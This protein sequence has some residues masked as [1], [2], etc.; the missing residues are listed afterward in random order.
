MISRIDLRGSL[1]GDLRSV[2][3]RAE[4]DV[5][6]AL[7]KVRPICED[8]RHRGSDAVREYTRAFD[9]V[10]LESTRVPVAAVH[11]ALA[12][13]DPAV[14][15]ALEESIR[16]AR[17]VHR[18]QRRTDV[19]T[20][21]APGGTV[22]E[23]WIP[24]GRVGL[25]VPGGRAVYPSSVVM[26]VVPAQEAGVGSLAVTS[27]AQKDFGGLP[28]PTILAACALLGVDEVYAAGG[29]QAIAMFAYGTG[30]CPR[31][32][33]VTGPGN[34]YVAAAKRLLKG[35]IGIDAEAGPTEIAIL[36]DDTASPVDVAA[37][38]ISQA[39]HD[40]LAAAVLVTDSVRLA[41]EVETE[42]KAQVARTRHTE[43]I[44]EALAG[45]QSGIVL[46]DT[47]EDGL[48]V[49]DAYAA[50]HLEIQTA[51]AAAVAARVRNAGAVF[52]GPHAPVSLG[53]YL[54]GSNHVLPTGGCACH[55]SG[56]SVQSFLRGVHVVE[57]DRDAL[58]E[59]TARV[60][61]LAEAEDLPAHGAAL[62]AR[63][64]WEIPS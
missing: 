10:E 50:E 59:A 51:D 14:R 1:P 44:T 6:A 31:A 42:L 32:D 19:T 22:T 24:V 8:V 33:L 54:A 40:T 7:D 49:V 64:D 56:L 21:V 12:A 16:R 55:S 36:A 53:D 37:D 4:L 43:R 62:K 2:L 20:Q 25:Y 61:A 29:A 18:D 13:L 15:D 39:E 57:Y 46:V 63:F 3:P 47:V 41:D 35:V 9:G 27:P 34:V 17:A 58:A 48:K 28:H 26:N 52:V 45:R 5:E 38:L 30:E 23:R 11:Q 60:V